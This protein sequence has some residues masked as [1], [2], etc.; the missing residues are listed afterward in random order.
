MQNDL[1]YANRT[2]AILKQFDIK[3]TKML[4]AKIRSLSTKEEVDRLRTSL[5][6]ERLEKEATVNGYELSRP[7]KGK[8]KKNNYDS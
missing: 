7:T 2:L 8:R 5:Q 1:E 4:K 6:K 3:I